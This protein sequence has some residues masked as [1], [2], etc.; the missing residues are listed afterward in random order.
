MEDKWKVWKVSLE[1]CV[2]SSSVRHQVTQKVFVIKV[3]K[4]FY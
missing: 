2:L 1:E 3:R 4:E